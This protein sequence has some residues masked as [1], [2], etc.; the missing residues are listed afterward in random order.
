MKQPRDKRTRN[1]IVKLTERDH[2]VLIA[3]SRFRAARTSD[4]RRAVFPGLHKDTAGE[5]LRKLFD[6]DYVSVHL[7]DRSEENVYSLGKGGREWLRDRGHEAGRFPQGDLKHHLE[8][9][10]V[11]TSLVVAVRATPGMSFLRARPDWELRSEAAGA[12]LVPDMIAV[13]QGARPV[14]LAIEV[15]R[16]SEPARLLNDKAQRYEYARESGEGIWGLPDTNLCIFAP[17][18][19]P[20]RLRSIESA[21]R[22]AWGGP[23]YLWTS[24]PEIGASVRSIGA[25]EDH[26]TDSPYGTGSRQRVSDAAD[27]GSDSNEPGP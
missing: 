14:G 4:L 21:V 6:S 13:L 22:A 26:R 7:G 19:G 27:S 17:E 15:D 11:W 18:A 2:R 16:G 12:E 23:L 3:L 1:R 9:V 10:R 24:E 25:R 20:G 8:I 5:R